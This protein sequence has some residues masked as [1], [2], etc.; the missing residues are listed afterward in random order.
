MTVNV[1]LCRLI[2]LKNIVG[3]NFT[4]L[5]ATASSD[6]F[7]NGTAAVTQ[8][9][10]SQPQV[11]DREGDITTESR[12]NNPVFTTL[13]TSTDDDNNNDHENDIGNQVM[14]WHRHLQRFIIKNQFLHKL[15]V[16]VAVVYRNYV[17]VYN[18]T[19]FA[20]ILEI[21]KSP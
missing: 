5:G 8:P 11:T 20:L 10:L 4:T 21:L 19:W 12:Q 6:S 13:G 2:S 18:L 1:L 3:H 14:L 16:A 17:Y 7:T 9:N 15:W